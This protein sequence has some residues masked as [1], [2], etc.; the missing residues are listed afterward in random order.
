[1]RREHDSPQLM[2][3]PL[4]G[5][6]TMGFNVENLFIQSDTLDATLAA[7]REYL[8][9]ASD[10]LVPEG[11]PLEAS[12]PRP[13]RRKIAVSD[14]RQGWIAMVADTEFVEPALAVFLSARLSTRVVIAQLFEVSGD[15]GVAVIDSGVVASG[16]TRDD[17]EDP[18]AA[19]RAKLE[20]HGVPFEVVTFRETV[21]RNGAG[22]QHVAA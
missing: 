1:V 20:G 21:A 13:I 3:K 14:A 22:W 18:L 16:P 7:L 4:G 8:A 5:Q 17:I 19:V 10:E 9:T 11:W 12:A 2:R 6:T 15:A